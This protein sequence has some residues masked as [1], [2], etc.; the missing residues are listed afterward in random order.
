MP[1]FSRNH[2]VDALSK[3]LRRIALGQML[4]RPSNVELCQRFM[5]ALVVI[6]NPADGDIILADDRGEL[7]LCVDIGTRQQQPE[8]GTKMP[9]VRP[10]S[11]RQAAVEQAQTNAFDGGIRSEQTRCM[12]RM[13]GH[14]NGGSLKARNLRE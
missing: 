6:I 8:A 9:F 5:I 14:R 7:H 12:A 1:A 2:P 3:C 13:S 11:A 4:T 10:V